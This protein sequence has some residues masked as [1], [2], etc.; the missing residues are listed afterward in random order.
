MVH[1][2][3]WLIEKNP[4]HTWKLK[5]RVNNNK[6]NTLISTVFRILPFKDCNYGMSMLLDNIRY[7]IVEKNSQDIGE[8]TCLKL[9]QIFMC[10]TVN[11]LDIKK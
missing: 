3:N 10:D 1:Q 11:A 9:S 2:I 6:K 8:I 5:K 7:Y 4:L